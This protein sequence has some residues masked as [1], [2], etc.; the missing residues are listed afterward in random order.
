[1]TLDDLPLVLTVEETAEAL[2]TS[3]WR[4]YKSVAAGELRAVKLG[5]CLRIP[6]QAI[7]DLLNGAETP[8]AHGVPAAGPG[9]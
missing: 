1:M 2:R 6:R 3:P 7:I 8:A 9:A 5:R 4:V